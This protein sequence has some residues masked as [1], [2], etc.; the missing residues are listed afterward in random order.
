MIKPWPQWWA[1]L[2]VDTK[3]SIQTCRNN[4]T[5]LIS[6]VKPCETLALQ[7][8]AKKRK[9]NKGLKNKSLKENAGDKLT[10]YPEQK[11][12]EVAQGRERENDAKELVRIQDTSL[13]EKQ[14]SKNPSI[15]SAE[16]IFTFTSNGSKAHSKL[17][18]RISKAL[19]KQSAASS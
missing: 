3:Y 5:D 4:D 16:K 12:E 9:S 11:K 19:L 15:M 18:D 7:R 1:I 13:S 6:I 8:L 17:T 10:G 2:K 14:D